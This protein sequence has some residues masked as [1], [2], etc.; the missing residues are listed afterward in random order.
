M[1]KKVTL[2]ELP[3]N[4]NNCYKIQLNKQTLNIF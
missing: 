3:Y 2:D 4:K 1:E